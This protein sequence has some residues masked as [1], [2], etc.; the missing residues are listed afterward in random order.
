MHMCVCVIVCV[1]ELTH[2]LV[3]VRAN[4]A[5]NKKCVYMW[6]YSACIDIFGMQIVP[7]LYCN[8]TSYIYDVNLLYF[9]AI[10]ETKQ[11]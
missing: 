9:G 4:E 7:F 3:C 5:V 6:V 2:L 1:G 10:G 11:C 8:V